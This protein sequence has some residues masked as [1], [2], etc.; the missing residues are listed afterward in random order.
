MRAKSDTLEHHSSHGHRAERI[1]PSQA[2]AARTNE[3]R[4]WQAA[5]IVGLVLCAAY[6]A[7]PPEHAAARNLGIYAPTELG[8]ILAIIFGVR[9][10]RPEAPQ[11]W[12][13]IA[14]GLFL[15]LIGDVVWGVYELLGRDPWP[16]A[17]DWFYLAGY[18]LVAAGLIVGIR[19]REPTSDRRAVIDA[20][21]VAVSAALLA[22][23]YIVQ[24]ARAGFDLTP[25]ETL[26]TVAYPFGDVLLLAVAARLVI[27]GSWNVLALR[28]LVLGLLLFLV[29]DT[30]YA[31]D[32]LARLPEHLRFE[33]TMLL[34]GVV[35]IGV[36]GLHR[37]MPALTEGATEPRAPRDTLRLVLLG[38][39]CLVPPIVLSVQALRGEP[40]EYV[41]VIVSMVVL[42]GLVVAR[43]TD[44]T[45]R[46][47]RAAARDATIGRYSADLLGANGR[48]E[49]FALAERTACELI[50]SGKAQLVEPEEHDHDFTAPVLVQGGRVADLVVDAAP[51]RLRPVRDSLTS[52][53]AQLSLALERERLLRRSARSPL[54]SRNRTNGCTS[55]IA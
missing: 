21:I 25:V 31:L 18:P 27:G 41:A 32:A 7:V 10:Y 17:A 11:A 20:C 26:V 33:D 19:N 34:L 47:E 24:P 15:Y 12:L 29:A 8:A 5:L 43:F 4:L 28:L 49:L 36:A 46:A 22:W 30:V 6:A 55:S 3:T 1:V 13:L 14:A 39:V 51:S 23:V 54:L 45:T 48:T 9:R 44:I 35:S 40:L 16:S 42:C 53:A 37:S 38:G 50:G 2:A 52:V